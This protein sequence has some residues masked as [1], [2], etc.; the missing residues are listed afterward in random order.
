MFRILVEHGGV[1]RATV[2]T[3]TNRREFYA[4][5]SDPAPDLED[6]VDASFLKV[7][8]EAGVPF[9]HPYFVPEV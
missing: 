3:Q 9:T 5:F 2:A 7:C 1:V 8:Q 6:L 4:E